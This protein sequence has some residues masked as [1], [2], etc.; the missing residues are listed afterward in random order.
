MNFFQAFFDTDETIVRGR[1]GQRHR[2]IFVHQPDVRPWRGAGAPHQAVSPKAWTVFGGF[3]PTAVPDDCLNT[4]EWTRS[5]WARASGRS[6]DCP[7]QSERLVKGDPVDDI[8]ELPF[9]DRELIRNERDIELAHRYTGKRMTSFQSCRVCPLQCVFCAERVVTG[10]FN[11]V[12]NPVR[13]VTPERLL[14]E[15]ERVARHYRLDHFKFADA[16]GTHRP[17]R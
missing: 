12:T 9:A 13:I 1:S 2:G 10:K 8:N 7:G 5:S 14:D 16:T 6:V 3:H 15:I 4:R 11:R 17:R